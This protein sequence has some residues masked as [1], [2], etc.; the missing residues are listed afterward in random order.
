MNLVAARGLIPDITFFIDIPI[1]EIGRRMKLQQTA[2][3]RMESNGALFY[4]QVRAGYFALAAEE[5]RVIVMDGTQSRENLQ[6]QIWSC[7]EEHL[8]RRQHA[9]EV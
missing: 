5:P 4:E 2:A 8:V 3:D 1:E 9:K 6:K 7:T